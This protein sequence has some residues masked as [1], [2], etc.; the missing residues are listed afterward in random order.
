MWD[1]VAVAVGGGPV[2]AGR[3]RA[4]RR[5][6][7][8]AAD[9]PCHRVPRLDRPGL[10]GAVRRLGEGLLREW[11]VRGAI[12]VVAAAVRAAARPFEVNPTGD[13]ANCGN[14]VIAGDATRS[15]V[16]TVA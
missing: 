10:P 12:A 8:E 11:R 15:G 1:A 9:R 5:A 6:R 4:Q 3:G 14:C 2:R 7:P 16:P 13:M